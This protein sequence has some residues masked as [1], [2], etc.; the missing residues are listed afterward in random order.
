M[1]GGGSSGGGGGGS[2]KVDWPDYFKQLHERWLNTGVTPY[3]AATDDEGTMNSDVSMEQAMWEAWDN[4]PYSTAFTY[5]PETDLSDVEARLSAE[6]SVVDGKNAAVNVDAWY[7]AAVA[8]VD[9]AVVDTTSLS[10]AVTAYEGRKVNTHLRNVGRF[11]AGMADLNATATSAYVLG[12]AMLESEFARDVADFNKQL[13]YEAYKI[14][15]DLVARAVDDMHRAT[16]ENDQFLHN[17]NALVADWTRVK[18]LVMREYYDRD[19]EIAVKD[20]LWN[21]EIWQNAGNLLASA[22]GGVTPTRTQE[23]GGK[24]GGGLTSML[25]GALGGA[26]TGAM[27]GSAIPGV[28]TAIGASVGAIVGGLAAS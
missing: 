25:G 17:Y 27:V 6:A 4:S 24:S 11:A 20:H 1:S 7:D 16:V 28:G 3:S 12:L 22:Q 21:I 2:G 9:G 23:Q 18:T 19:L 14:R 15:T 26:G 5:D 13:T 10:G 8:T